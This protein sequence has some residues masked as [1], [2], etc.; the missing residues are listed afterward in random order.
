MR[1]LTAALLLVGLGAPGFGATV[2]VND[3][4]A[5][6]A[7]FNDATAVA[8][9]GGNPGT[10]LGAQ[11]LN[12]FSYAAQIWGGQLLSAVTIEV[13]AEMTALACTATA[14]TLG[15]AGANSLHRDFTGAPIAATWYPQALANK[16]AGTDLNPG[17]ADIHA[18]FNSSIGTTCPFP[19]VWYYGFDAN[20][21]SGQ[22][23][24]IAVVLHELGHGLGFG[25]P[26]A[27]D[28]AK[29]AGF[30]DA[31][32]L[33]LEDH[34]L[35]LGWG[36]MTN[37]QRTA[38]SIDTGDLHWTGPSV[39][40]NG[41]FLVDGRD[42]MSGHVEM[43]AP[44]PYKPGSSVSH[45]S[46]DCS[47][48]EL[49]EP[50][51]T[52]PN[53][54]TSLARNALDD[55]G[56][57]PNLCGNNVIDPGE[58]CDDGGNL[59]GDCCAPDCTYAASG[60]GC[61]DG[62]PC[63]IGDTCDGAGGCSAG[64]P[65]PCDDANVCTADSCV[66]FTGCVHTPAPGPCE[67]GN[68]CTLGDTCGGGTCQAGTNFPC[69]L[70]NVCDGAGGCLE[71]PATGCKTPIV[72]AKSQL[73]VKD[74]TPSDGDQV[75]FKWITGSAT[76]LFEL[77]APQSTDDYALCVWDESG[78]PN[79]LFSMHA[80]AG[81]TCGAAPCWKATGTSGFKYKNKLHTPDG[82]DTLALKAGANKKA[83]VTIKGKGLNL[84]N[85]PATPLPLPLRAQVQGE[86]GT[87]FEATFSTPLKNTDG[88]FKA[89]AD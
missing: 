51:Y 32:M 33:K 48:D 24:F 60:S 10:T 53:H 4:N 19:S 74:K 62:D 26:I 27:A 82:T 75:A 42:G 68:P 83:K 67:D 12:A 47:P 59:P 18:S 66:S 54:L 56:W 43:Y 76:T 71:Q 14:A 57:G 85:V 30:D 21:P 79:L 6:G 11:R 55:I 81:G 34:S 22:I 35:S 50:N 5:P 16:L 23:D 13:D 52:G 58:D 65:D 7:G 44:N 8:P 36:A 29:L 41:G 61:D 77:G 38:S 88:Q 31:F 84:F 45:F 46:I 78:P 63:S 64:G 1:T 49:M 25:T 28:G 15:S 3:V 89:K 20:P 73:Q 69:P 9:I 40:T 86:N 2:V 72:S 37:A 17:T 70:C 80:P 39:V 87:C